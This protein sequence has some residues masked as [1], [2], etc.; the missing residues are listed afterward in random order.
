VRITKVIVFFTTNP[1]KLVLQFSEFS[2]ISYVIYKDQQNCNTIEDVVL[3]RGPATFQSLTHIPLDRTKLP[4]KTWGLAMPPLAVG[5]AR[6]RP[7][8]ASRRRSRPASGWARLGA[9]L[10]RRGGRGSR[11][12]SPTRA[13]GGCRRGRPR[14]LVVTV[15]RMFCWAT[16]DPGGAIGPR[17]C[18]RE[19]GRSG[20]NGNGRRRGCSGGGNGGMEE[21]VAHGEG[22]RGWFY[23]RARSW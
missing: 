15:R 13:C 9:H 20:C 8:P 22:E 14:Q 19:L 18:A 12:G 7:I 17:E 11:G 6:L 23:R 4:G 5:A 1:T 2:K 21:A 16:R 3:R 10:G